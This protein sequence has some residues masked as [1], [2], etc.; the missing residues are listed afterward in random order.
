MANE[1]FT[2]RLNFYQSANADAGSIKDDFIVRLQE[3]DIIMDD[4]RSNT[5]EGSVQHYLLIGRRGSGKSTLLKRIQVEIEGDENLT[6]KYIPINPA[7]EQASIYKL[8]DL[9]A[10]IIQELQHKGIEVDEPEFGNDEQAYTMEMF[11]AI[12]SA[13]ISSG[14][15][16][17]LLLDNI[18]RIL[19]NISVDA[20]L[21]REVLLNYDDI[22]IIGGSTKMTEHFWEYNKPF[23]QFFRVLELNALT[24][25]EI[26][27]LMSHWSDKLN[28][29]IL[30]EFVENKPGQLEAVRILTDGLPRTLQFFVNILINRQQE[31]GYE[32]MKLIMDQMTPLYQ[33]RLNSLSPAHRKIVLQMAFIWEAAGAKEIAA[34]AKMNNN[35]TSAQL[36]QL[37]DKG[38]VEKVETSTKNHL[39]RLLERFFNLWLIFTQGSPHE[40]RRAKYLTIFLENFYDEQELIALVKDHIQCLE[41][42]TLHPD[43]AV[44]L[45]KAFAQL[46]NIS[47][48][49]RDLLI[50]KTKSLQNITKDAMLQLPRTI[51]ELFTDIENCFKKERW[52]ECLK[53]INSIEQED[54]IKDSFLGAYYVQRDDLMNAE[55][56]YKN[57]L[58]KG[59]VLI[60]PSLAHVYDANNKIGLA[61]EYYIKSI[62]LDPYKGY[63]EIG[64]FYTKHDRNQLAIDN[65]KKAAELGNNDALLEIGM[66]YEKMEKPSEAEKYYKKAI[67]KGV[68]KAYH[69]LAYMYNNIKKYGLAEEYYKKA[70]E[71]GDIHAIYNL[72]YLYDE[73]EK[74]AEA[75]Y[76]YKK[77]I[78]QDPTYKG[79]ILNLALLY[80][81]N[82]K[83][84]D[85]A[86]DLVKGVDIDDNMGKSYMLKV[87]ILIWN[88]L[89]INLLQEVKLILSKYPLITSFIFDLLVH[90][91]VRT[92]Y[93]LFTDATYGKELTEKNLPLFYATQVLIEN[94]TNL[95]KM[96]PEISETVNEIVLSIKDRR[97]FFYE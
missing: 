89:P 76:Y 28:L 72:A 12:H 60:M 14:K 83:N 50:T 3:Y 19:E 88:G 93:D 49:D 48:R 18:D 56:Y 21:L 74:E 26:K 17:I 70:I 62:Q 4:I 34:A 78:E 8:Y 86:L 23:Y 15:K 53:L 47:F 7:E 30:K 58:D 80:Y 27:Q 85:E 92:V 1:I 33:E 42:R 38:I 73:L 69:I 29:P 77:T 40:K 71:T 37:T 46:K 25:E 54:G 10:S 51:T 2:S 95:L 41:S 82:G 91:Q 94:E 24:S 45:T 6:A 20:G 44:V 36:K 16:I 61:E 64:E 65:F 79:A 22:K 87:I 35:T 59:F 66:L 11:Q 52:G 13:I 84:K 39:Y 63:F 81:I 43:K 67:D 90:Y 96:P 68:A 9:W 32:Y 57:A 97:K 75:E 31:T 5:M 55:K